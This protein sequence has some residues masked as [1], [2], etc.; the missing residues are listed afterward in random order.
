MTS[1]ARADA[2]L[3][4][5]GT[6]RCDLQRWWGDHGKINGRGEEVRPFSITSG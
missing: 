6:Y 2:T 1:Y 3:S 4:G 5:C